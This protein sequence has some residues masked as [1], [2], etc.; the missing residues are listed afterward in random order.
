MTPQNC[1]P[2]NY[3]PL[4]STLLT[5]KYTLPSNL[6]KLPSHLPL[7]FVNSLFYINN[8]YWCFTHLN[9]VHHSICL[10][11]EGFLFFCLPDF[12]LSFPPSAVFRDCQAIF[13]TVL[14]Y[15]N[16]FHS[17]TM[18]TNS[19]LSSPQTAYPLACSRLTHSRLQEKKKFSKRK[20]KYPDRIHSHPASQSI[21]STPVFTQYN[22]N[23]NCLY[24]MHQYQFS[25]DPVSFGVQWK[26]KDR[27]L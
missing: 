4:P 9:E 1:L 7:Y 23:I 16:F 25:C 26:G 11:D 24:K 3:L 22:K 8:I 15:Y 21:K 20:C 5:V 14:R 10:I 12:S 13:L 19:C 2:D 27:S 17:F 18:T 6:V